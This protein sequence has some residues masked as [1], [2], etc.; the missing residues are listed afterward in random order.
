ESVLRA[1]VADIASS[2]NERALGFGWLG[3]VWG[4]AWAIGNIIG[5]ALYDFLGPQ[6]LCILYPVSSFL[7]LIYFI[8]HYLQ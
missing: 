5:G 2:V 1:A 6:V 4:T 3:F 8:K 7:S